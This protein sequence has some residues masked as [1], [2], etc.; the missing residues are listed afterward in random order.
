MSNLP[1]IVKCAN[2]LQYLAKKKYIS[3]LF[4][5]ALSGPPAPPS[6]ASTVDAM[7]AHQVILDQNDD[8]EDG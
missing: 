6:D 3:S 7:I 1:K 4:Q 8:L 5:S 2:S